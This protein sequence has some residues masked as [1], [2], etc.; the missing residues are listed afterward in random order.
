MLRRARFIYHP[1]LAPRLLQLIVIWL[2]L[3]K[4][5]A[6]ATNVGCHEYGLRRNPATSK[7][8]V[9][10]S[11]PTI[12]HLCT[13][14][15][16]LTNFYRLHTEE[17]ATSH[18]IGLVSL[19]S[20][21]LAGDVELK[22]GPRS[23]LSSAAIKFPCGICKKACTWSSRK[24]SIACDDCNTWFHKD[25]LNMPTAVFRGIT[26]A[27][28]WRCC[29]CGMPNL[30]DSS[31]FYHPNSSSECSSSASLISTSNTTSLSTDES[32]GSPVLTSTPIKRKP[33]KA[34]TRK[35][36]F[37]TLVIN[38]QSIFRKHH[39]LSL[40][41]E[42]L[43]PDIILATET[44]L[45][46][47]ICD[48]EFLPAGYVTAA[49]ADREHDG[50]GGSLIAVRNN[51]C[52][53]NIPIDNK[54][55]I[56][57]EISAAK[58]TT[59]HNQPDI[60]IVSVYRPPNNDTT[61]ASYIM[62]SI[63]SL[64]AKYRKATFW[65]GGDFN[66]PDIDWDMSTIRISP[67]S[68]Q[69]HYSKAINESFLSLKTDLGIEQSVTEPTR[70]NNCLD[71]FVTNR[72]SLV[73]RAEVVPGVSDHAAV[74]VDTQTLVSHFKQPRRQILL[75]S[76]ADM[77]NIRKI[78]KT[79]SDNILNLY[80][81]ESP[82]DQIWSSIKDGLTQALKQVPTKMTSSKRSQP[83]A[84]TTV[85]RMSRRKH[86]AMKTALK[87]G[88]WD[89]YN[90]VKRQLQRECR[91]AH[92][93]WLN[94]MIEEG[95]KK[96]LW[97]YVKSKRKDSYG[98]SAL[99]DNGQ[100]ITDN[101]KQADIL[102]SQFSSVFSREDCGSIPDLGPSP[103][104]KASNITVTMPGVKKL[105]QQLNPHTANGPDQIP[106]RLLKDCAEELTP[107][108]SLLFQASINQH[109]IPA[110]W[111]KAHIVPAFKKGD[112]GKAENYRPISLTSVLCKS[113]EHIIHS[114]LMNHFDQHHVLC[115][116]QHGFRKKR[117]CESQLL[118][119]VQDLAKT[120][121]D[122]EQMDCILLDFSKAFD[123]VPHQRLLA[124]LYHYGVRG[125]LLAWIQ[126]F[127]NARTQKVLVNSEESE[128]APVLSGVPQGSVLGPL[129]FLVFINDIPNDIS[130]ESKLRLYADDGLLYRRVRH[131]NDSAGLQEDLNKLQ[132]WEHK[133]LMKFN[134]EKCF[135]LRV[136]NKT[137]PINSDYSIH[138]C[139]LDP[140][141]DYL[142]TAKRKLAHNRAPADKSLPNTAKY[143]GVYINSKLS[144][145]H[146]V[147]AI[148]KKA[149]STL[150]FLNRNTAHCSRDIK[151]YCY[152]TYVRPQL[153][154]ASTVWSPH[155][156][157]NIDKLEMVQRNAAR[158][159]FQ[160][161]SRHSSPT[162]MMKELQWESLEQRRLIARL[163]MMYRIQYGLIDIPASYTTRSHSLRGHPVMLQQVRCRV[164]PYEASFFPAIVIPWNYLPASVVTAPSINT[165][166][167][168]VPAAVCP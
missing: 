63:K 18:P 35:P 165:F 118:L 72:P 141:T 121:D 3:V 125:N 53:Q 82:V 95:G 97:S 10:S 64:M 119:A 15:S 70:G 86:R 46:Q 60:V 164:K 23:S 88:K 131:I 90:S 156:K 9:Q 140:A 142:P 103:Y 132:E 17:L 167:S 29:Q 92:D 153:E 129:L 139:Q 136:T 100:L 36:N 122:G 44:H 109:S 25:C 13:N 71:L 58:V 110:E 99:K 57:A 6:C 152:H 144:W 62:D 19:L 149:R 55:H 24:P 106:S 76:K 162:A 127:L 85:K 42:S 133:W 93:H 101:Q 96:R 68:K 22:P 102:N 94:S 145:N 98:V 43:S 50:Y 74:L 40:T 14:T 143:L 120:L 66:L 78:L 124:K 84:N 48:A 16:R 31:L 155:T 123:K 73:K 7:L 30:T 158:Y 160:D 163:V 87:T 80:D 154:Y 130:P 135:T 107:V 157:A 5:I 108:I 41:C 128:E 21:L 159:V 32:V 77:D 61:I 1:T 20:L 39:T 65:I 75:W 113:L 81:L 146:H 112:R 105:L 116:E 37:R 52:T 134:P 11:I 89:R 151:Q 33:Q 59:P 45:T 83:W 166:K 2:L 26:T 111:K 115:D 161:F 67:G 8:Y 51:L 12:V 114:H 34:Y 69:L 27:D 104:P 79:I 38:T 117:S 137:K 54:D 47:A 49:R 168:R 4:Y 91:H 147:D 148:T 28:S 56:G 138:G 126:D 150:W